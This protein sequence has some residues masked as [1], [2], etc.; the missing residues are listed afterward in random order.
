[1]RKPVHVD[2]QWQRLEWLPEETWRRDTLPNLLDR[3][4]KP[5]ALKRCVYVIRLNGDFCIDYPSG[6]SPVVYIGEGAFGSRIVQHR[7][8]MAELR[9]LVGE[10]AFQVRIAIPRVRRN[11]AAYKDTEAA[12][13]LRFKE[14]Y[15]SLPLWNKQLEYRRHPHYVYEQQS[16]DDA[17]GLGSGKR[18]KWAL[19]PMKASPFYADY[20]R[21]H[22]D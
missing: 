6:E 17:I 12:L 18:Y 21:T 4:F 10:F 9:D 14:R 15:G 2:L 22:V 20:L 3:G 1:V 8:W 19:K 5:L 7:S 11:P 13:L 16:V